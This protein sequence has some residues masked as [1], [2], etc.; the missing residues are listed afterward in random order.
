MSNRNEYKEGVRECK[1]HSLFEKTVPLNF[2]NLK[3]DINFHI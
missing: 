3:K 2:S 1:A